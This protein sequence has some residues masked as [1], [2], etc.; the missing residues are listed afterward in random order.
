MKQK[1]TRFFARLAFMTLLI[2]LLGWALQTVLPDSTVSPAFP[3]I[4][5]LF[6]ITTALIHLVL[7]SITRLNPRR[8]VSYFMLATFIKLLL[9]FIAV[10]IYLFNFR[11]NALSFIVTFM[12]LYILYTVFETILIL[13]QTR[14]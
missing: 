10:L 1:Y 5:G 9:Y 8:F 2:A 13:H 14:E 3:F 6:F 12:I 4:L 7:L 11:E